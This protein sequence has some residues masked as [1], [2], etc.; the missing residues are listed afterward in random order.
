MSLRVGASERVCTA[1][2]TSSTA[3]SC[4]TCMQIVLKSRRVLVGSTF[5][6]GRV[7]DFSYDKL[8]SV[9]SPCLFVVPADVATG[10]CPLN[11]IV[12]HSQH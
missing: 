5:V 7:P 8:S 2:T 10:T 12:Y 3:I 11:T 9:E 6:Q 4:S 1:V